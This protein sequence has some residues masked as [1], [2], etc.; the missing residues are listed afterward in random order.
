MI[1]WES[2]EGSH[3]EVELAGGVTLR[4]EVRRS[5][6]KFPSEMWEWCAVA[7]KMTP[8]GIMTSTYDGVARHEL[9]A[10]M[11]ASESTL[12]VLDDLENEK[13]GGAR[14]PAG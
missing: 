7:E 13:G 11:R 6:K 5:L 3:Y 8:E 2:I 4:A 12:L 10:L 14:T 9:D 1:E